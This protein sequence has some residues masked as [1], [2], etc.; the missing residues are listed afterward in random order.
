MVIGYAVLVALYSYIAFTRYMTMAFEKSREPWVAYIP[1][2]S[3][4]T[5]AI[6][7]NMPSWLVRARNCRILSSLSDVASLF[8]SVLDVSIQC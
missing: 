2:L 1:L 5:I 7:R 4:I 6:G 3:L 8:A